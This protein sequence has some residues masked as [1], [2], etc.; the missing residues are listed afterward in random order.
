MHRSSLI[1]QSFNRNKYKKITEISKN[2]KIVLKKYSVLK[3]KSGF[4]TMKVIENMIMV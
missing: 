2:S 4:Q 1:L 3:F